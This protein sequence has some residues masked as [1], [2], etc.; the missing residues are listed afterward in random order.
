MFVTLFLGLLDTRTGALTYTNAGHPAPHI[1]RAAGEIE[2]IEGTLDV[3]LG[4]RS[5]ATYRTST[6]TLLRG[7]AVLVVSDGVVEATNAEGD[8]YTIERM[9]SV[10]RGAGKASAADLVRAVT[11]HVRDF[12]GSAPKADDVTALAIRWLPS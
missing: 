12:A 11:D 4:V 3:P 8:F 10:L 9:N 6:V 2:Q 1:L 5:K 7:D